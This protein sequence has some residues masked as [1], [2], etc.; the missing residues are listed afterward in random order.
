[1]LV[2][3]PRLAHRASVRPLASRV[4]SPVIC[5]F[6]LISVTCGDQ[7]RLCG[8]ESIGSLV[9]A[10]S[11]GS[12]L[13][14]GCVGGSMRVEVHLSGS[15]MASCIGTLLPLLVLLALR[16]Y[17]RWMRDNSVKK[18]ACDRAGRC[19]GQAPLSSLCGTLRSCDYSGPLFGC[20]GDG[21]VH[22]IALVG[23]EHL[24][25]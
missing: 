17:T 7:H 10:A 11:Y 24:R 13:S 5:L 20:F 19:M 3:S 22:T 15:V 21:K 12:V 16:R 18:S 8:F 25:L 6:C 2:S 14:V 23:A 1:M 4:C 9:S